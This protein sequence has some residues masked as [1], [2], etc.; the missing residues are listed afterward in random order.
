[1]GCVAEG[2]GFNVTSI[3]IESTT[4]SRYCPK[5]KNI[6]IKL[7][8]DADT[9]KLIGAQAIEGEGVSG[10]INTLATALTNH[11][12]VYDVSMLDL[13]YSPPFAPVWD[14]IIVVANVLLRKMKRQ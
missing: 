10:R 8:A 12:S 2:E 5:I 9:Q 11:M 7:I 4:R 1:M 14:P 13:A 6:K 3:V